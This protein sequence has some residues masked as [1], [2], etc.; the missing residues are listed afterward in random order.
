TQET[1]QFLQQNC[2]WRSLSGR[3]ADCAAFGVARMG[4]PASGAL[5]RSYGSDPIQ[6]VDL[7]HAE[8]LRGTFGD[9][10]SGDVEG[11]QRR[12]EE[13]R[14]NRRT[15]HC[16]H[17]ALQLAAN[18]LR[19][20]TRDSRASSPAALPQS[21]DTRVG[22]H[23]E[24]DRRPVDGVGHSFHQ[25]KAAWPQIL[26]TFAGEP[27]RGTR[28][29][30]GSVAFKPRRLRDVPDLAEAIGAAVA[31]SSRIRQAGGTPG[32][33]SR[34]RGDYRID[35]GAGDWRSVSLF[36][37][38]QSHELLRPDHS[39]E[40][41]CRQTAAWPHFETAQCLAADGIDRGSQAG[42]AMEPA[43]SGAACARA[44]AR[45]PQS[46]HPCSRTQARSLSVGCRQTGTAVPAPHAIAHRHDARD[47]LRKNCGD[48]EIQITTSGFPHPHSS[49]SCGCCRYF[50]FELAGDLPAGSRLLGDCAEEYLLPMLPSVCFETGRFTQTQ[51]SW[52]VPRHRSRKWMSGQAAAL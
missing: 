13:E 50:Q 27:G 33:Y 10:T 32:E 47:R 20:H 48:V 49:G 24:Q 5:A 17:G 42:P 34:S 44:R 11:N 36:L 39:P 1:H 14:P 41:L 31:G 15:H 23:A 12:K 18:V 2:R 4:E 16:R 7:R 19:S 28:L 8:T 35:L 26:H 6:R 22:A 46:G 25:R 9:G 30:E 38:G 37:F 45:A 51:S 29:G 21:S 52:T 40:I 43:V 3:E